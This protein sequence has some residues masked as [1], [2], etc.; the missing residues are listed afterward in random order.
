MLTQ[1][2][3]LF[4]LTFRNKI[5]DRINVLRPRESQQEIRVGFEGKSQQILTTRAGTTVTTNSFNSYELRNND[6]LQHEKLNAIR[7]DT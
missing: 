2:G 4:D 3:S 7:S 6:E 1:K 5:D